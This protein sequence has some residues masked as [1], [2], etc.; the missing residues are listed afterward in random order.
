MDAFKLFY[1]AV[2]KSAQLSA[3]RSSKLG[4]L[5]TKLSEFGKLAKD[6]GDADALKAARSG[7]IRY[8]ITGE[9]VDPTMTISFFGDLSQ[10]AALLAANA[11]GTD[12]KTAALKAK[13][14]ALQDFIAG[15][16]VIANKASGKNRVGR[17][18]SESKGISVYLPPVETRIPQDKLE[19]IFEGKYADFAR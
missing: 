11:K 13:A 17:D 2:K 12:V 19:G 14:A 18:L 7:V 4:D 5:G 6:A 16:L 10:Y 3:I 1:D 9:K 8:D 15:E